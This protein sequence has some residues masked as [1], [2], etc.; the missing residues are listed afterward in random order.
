[1]LGDAIAARDVEGDAACARIDKGHLRDAWAVRCV[2]EQHAKADG[3][4]KGR[5]RLLKAAEGLKRVPLV[6]REF[7]P[8][9]VQLRPRG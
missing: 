3:L 9:T 1:M 4:G 6:D 5:Q 2:G 7:G 8:F